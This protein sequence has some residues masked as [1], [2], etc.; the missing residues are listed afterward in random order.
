MA[1]GSIFLAGTKEEIVSNSL[2]KEK[3]LGSSLNNSCH[4]VS[5]NF[6]SEPNSGDDTI[7]SKIN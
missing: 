4:Q 2:A 3:Y 6:Q 7:P 5:K 1:D